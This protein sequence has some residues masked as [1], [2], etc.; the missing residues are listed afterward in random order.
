MAKEK[1]A[2]EIEMGILEDM[3]DEIGLDWK[4]SL[5]DL[6]EE[7]WREHIREKEESREAETKRQV[8]D[9]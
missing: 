8:G 9:P 5:G 6:I 4:R 2:V 7:L 3:Y 1:V